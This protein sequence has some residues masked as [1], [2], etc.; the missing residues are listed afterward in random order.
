MFHF[1]HLKLSIYDF[2]EHPTVLYLKSPSEK[3]RRKLEREVE[4]SV[5]IMLLYA[6]SAYQV[7]QNRKM[8][9]ATHLMSNEEQMRYESTYTYPTHMVYPYTV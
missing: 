3:I 6:A 2:Y 7:K 9:D 4:S 1:S 8:A 5:K